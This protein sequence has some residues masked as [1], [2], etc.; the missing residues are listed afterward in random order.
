M[1]T[2][3]SIFGAVSGLQL[4]IISAKLS[5]LIFRFG[6][7]GIKMSRIDFYSLILSTT[8]LVSALKIASYELADN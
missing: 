2:I 3:R 7:I 5:E 6:F 1:S 8:Q 4:F